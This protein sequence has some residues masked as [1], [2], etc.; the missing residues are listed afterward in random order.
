MKLT[1][2][3]AVP[4]KPARAAAR[5]AEP[6]THRLDALLHTMRTIAQHEDELCSLLHDARRTGRVNTALLRDLRAV[7]AA[8]PAE[9]YTDDLH[10]VLE[11]ADAA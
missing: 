10:A 8:L 4:A 1:G 9:E 2:K 11:I 6:L 5:K 3:K 7:L